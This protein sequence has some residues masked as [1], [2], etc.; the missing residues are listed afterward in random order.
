MNLYQK[1]DDS[2]SSPLLLQFGLFQPD[3]LFIKQDKSNGIK[4][5][6]EPNV[7]Q[8]FNLIHNKNEL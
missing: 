1:I 3:W 7:V 6:M 4:L 8:K 5:A 2:K